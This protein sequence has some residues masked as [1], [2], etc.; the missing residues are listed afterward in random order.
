MSSKGGGPPKKRES[1]SGTRKVSTLSAEQLERKR[2]NDREAQRSIRQRTKEH[3]EQL[4][5]QVTILQ[6]QVAEMRPQNERF[7]EL[8][9]RNAVLEEE[10]GRL[11]HLLAYGGRPSIAGSDEQVAASYRSGWTFDE[12]PGNA[13]SSIPTTGTILPSSYLAGTSHPP[14][15]RLSRTPSAVSVSSRSSHPHDWQQYATAR[16]PSLGDTSESEFSARMESYM[17]D[18]NLQPGSRLAPPPSIV[19][20]APQISFSGTASPSQQ[21]PESRISQIFPASQNQR[22]CHD[23]LQSSTLPSIDHT[24][25]AFVPSQ[26]TVSVSKPNVSAATQPSLAQSYPTSASS[27]QNPLAGQREQSYPF[28]WEPQS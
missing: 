12:D 25:P 14:S 21:P 6:A 7:N 9:Q 19:V 16:S 5:T 17:I 22:P 27:Y 15:S 4:E 24:A 11:K 20:A 8:L 3:I 23:T 18:G 28:P 1:R 13:A 2:A 26:R 10:V